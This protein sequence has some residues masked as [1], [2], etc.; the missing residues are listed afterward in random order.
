MFKLLCCIV[1][2][3][4]LFSAHLA[5]YRG[6]QFGMNTADAAKST[7]AVSANAK[8][9]HQRPRLIQQME[10]EPGRSSGYDS[11]NT[12]PVREA[13]LYFVDGELYRIV[14]TYDRYKV[15]GMT[16]DDMIEGISAKYGVSSK[17]AVEIP[18]L[19]NYAETAKVLARWQ[20][21]ESAYDLVRTGDQSSFALVLYSKRLDAQA[22]KAIG[23]ADRLDAQEAPQRE[24]EKQ[25]S[26][27]EAERIL[28][29]HARSLNKPNFRP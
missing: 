13:A 12:D 9:V 14:V 26:R 16:I 4:A 1:S 19:S 3:T 10:W 28:H 2:S 23:E 20:N 21:D 15:E 6:L 17:P 22:Q 5:S 27:A 29:D 7:G 8:T 24:I 11:T 18:F 25:K